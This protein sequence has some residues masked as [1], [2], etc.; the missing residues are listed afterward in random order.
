M[1]PG[2]DQQSA[3]APAKRAVGL[4]SGA[5]DFAFATPSKSSH[6]G[7]G[8]A[9]D[10]D[11]TP[12]MPMGMGMGVL[13]TPARVG[14]DQRS[15]PSRRELGEEGRTPT[16]SR[17]TI[18]PIREM[19]TS[20]RT[21]RP[22]LLSVS[23]AHASMMGGN[24]KKEESMKTPRKL[25]TLSSITTPWATSSNPRHD[26]PRTP[27]STSSKRRRLGDLE[28]HLPMGQ[29]GKEEKEDLGRRVAL[30]HMG[31]GVRLEGVGQIED[32]GKDEGEKEVGIGI[33]PRKGK[34]K[35]TGR[36][37]VLFSEMVT[38]LI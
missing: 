29:K 30:R 7:K 23:A 26:R 19:S 12:L 36:G 25:T 37:W 16:I 8:K 32:V 34:V 6:K 33:S 5:F 9:V 13:Q 18:T 38:E 35:W 3:Q 24:V 27:D 22:S 11:E 21:P 1:A 15:G 14:V 4:T 20:T 31:E 2:F 28:V 17:E 10:K